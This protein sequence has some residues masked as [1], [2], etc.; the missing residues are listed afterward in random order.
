MLPIYIEAEYEDGFV[1]RQ[2]ERDRS[3]YEEGRNVFYD[4][5]N[6]LPERAHG[7]T[8][9]FSLILENEHVHVDF[10]MLPDNARPI[11]FK[12]MERDSKDGVFIEEP[13][14][15]GID[16]GYQYTDEDGINQQEVME[17]R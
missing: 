15:V 8:V 12:H 10:T 3:L 9:R 2:D 16:F 1:H 13:R 7:S 17:I 4:I 11:C 6:R 5:N 14:I